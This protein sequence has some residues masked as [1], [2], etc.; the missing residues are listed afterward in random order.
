MTIDASDVH[1]VL[2]FRADTAIVRLLPAGLALCFLGLLGFA[3][4]DAES[5][6]TEMVLAICVLVVAGVG[7]T[8]FALWRRSNRSKPVFVLSPAGVH[9]RIA[10]VKTFLVPWREI[11]GIDTVN[12]T[13]WNWSIRNPGTMIFSNVTV[14]LVSKKFYDAHIFINSLLLR[15][16]A[17]ENIFITKGALV[18]VALH[19]ELV[20]VEPRVLR[21]AV[22]ARWHAFRDQ[23]S[24]SDGIPVKS[25]R[26][27]VPTVIAGWRKKI[28]RRDAAARPDSTSGVVAMGANPKAMPVWEAVQIIVPLIGIA[29]VL[30]NLL[31]LWAMQGQ[32]Q[33]REERKKWEERDRQQKEFRKKLDEEQ[34]ER[35]RRFQEMFRRM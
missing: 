6:S 27:S 8:V 1:Q 22:E 29:I 35:D 23:P 4:Y 21:D 25:A 17:W 14:F 33:A 9:Y 30:S 24:G 28:G 10:G 18:Q 26:A 19:H 7:I 11:R 34:K 2:E 3:L 16:P 5:P 31:G 15:G 20:S 12:I 32:V 13:S